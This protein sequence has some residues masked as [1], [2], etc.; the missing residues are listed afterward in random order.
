ME[1]DNGKVCPSSCRYEGQLVMQY[2][3]TVQGGGGWDLVSNTLRAA[4]V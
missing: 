3:K 4:A 1:T 2:R